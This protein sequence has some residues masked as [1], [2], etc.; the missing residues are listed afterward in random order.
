MVDSCI[1]I[2]KALICFLLFIQN[3]I[4]RYRYILNYGCERQNNIFAYMY[5]EFQFR[6]HDIN[7]LSFKSF[8]L[9]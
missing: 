4:D 6:A 7:N 8:K 9:T 2:I 1:D 3:Q 5:D